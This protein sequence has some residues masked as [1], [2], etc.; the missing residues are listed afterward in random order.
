VSSVDP[1]ERLREAVLK[2]TRE[3]GTQVVLFSAAVADRIGLA[4]NDV[5][6][7]EILGDE[8]PLTVGRLAEWTG[9]STGAATRMIDRLEQAGYVRRVADPADRRRVLVEPV[10]ERMAS[11]GALHD[12]IERAL[13]AVITR[14]S[15]EQLRA[16]FDYLAANIDVAREEAVRMRAPG[17]EGGGG[18]STAPVGATTAGRLVFLSGAPNVFLRGDPTLRELYRARFEGH[19]PRVRVRGGVV[20][21]HYSRFNWFDWRARFA[22]ANV[23]AMLHWRKDRGEI[24][25]NA[26]VP[27]DIELR[28]GASRLSADLGLVD[29]RS[30]ELAG[31]ASKIDLNLP[32][33]T[34][35]VSIRVTGGMSAVTIH[36]PSGV[37]ARLTVTGGAAQI[38]LDDQRVKGAGNLLLE[39]PGAGSAPA[40]YEVAIIGGA[41]RVT[42]DSR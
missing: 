22:E 15:E 23:E 12:P 40:R 7:L 3:V 8:G 19:V 30:F 10:A 28:G 26:R 38:V 42:L 13:R 9:L 33:P 20:T 27:W 17:D 16:I 14:F 35:V 32:Q 18:T 41:S 37:A 39:T 5:E 1:S 34:S 4:T 6:C 21:V 29:L 36:R 31:G 24:L 25:L 11:L 2:A